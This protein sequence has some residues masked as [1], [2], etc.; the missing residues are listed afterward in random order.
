MPRR[1]STVQECCG[2]CAI[3][4]SSLD[5]ARYVLHSSLYSRLQAVFIGVWST[6]LRN[7]AYVISGFSQPCHYL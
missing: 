1:G 2:M 4:I 7:L 5:R 6:S 3:N